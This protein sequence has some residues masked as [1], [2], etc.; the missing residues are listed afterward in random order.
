MAG[1][2]LVAATSQF[3]VTSC[4]L[5]GGSGFIL[6]HNNVTVDT[7][8][9]YALRMKD[10]TRKRIKPEADQLLLRRIEWEAG[11]YIDP[12]TGNVVLPAR[13][14]RAA[15]IAGAKK[16]KLGSLLQGGAIVFMKDNYDLNY[17]PPQ[18]TT[19]INGPYTDSRY[20]WHQLPHT[21]FDR[22][23]EYYAF[24]CPEKIGISTI[25]RTRP[26][27][28]NWSVNID[29]MFDETLIGINEIQ[30]LAYISGRQCGLG[31]KRKD[32]FGKFQAIEWATPVT[33]QEPRIL[34]A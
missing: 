16:L 32:G 24:S 34:A 26:I 17:V 19:R 13:M 12:S 1:K 28:Q 3:L 14:I 29:I 22:F 25:I 2:K 33:Y 9:P 31:D 10:L 21:E 20:D 23:Y 30:Q 6:L 8:H 4:K 15:F 18:G 5:D 27:F 11:L 7:L